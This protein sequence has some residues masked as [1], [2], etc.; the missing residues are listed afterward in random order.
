MYRPAAQTFVSYL[1]IEGKHKI[2]FSIYRLA[3]NLGMSIGPAIGGYIALHSFHSIF[4]VNAF[5]NILGGVILLAGLLDTPWINY[6]PATNNK[7]I[8]TLKW[9]KNDATLRVFI[10]G[11]IP[12]F[13]VF[14]QHESTLG[15]YLQQNL[16]LPL[17]SYGWIFTVNTLMIVCFELLLNI[18]TINWPYRIN[19]IIGS[20][21]ITAGFAGIYFATAMWHI[22]LLTM[23]WTLGEMILYPSASSY[24]ADIAP[25]KYRGGYMSLF[26]TSA[27]LGMLLGPWGGGL[28]MQQLGGQALWIT[29]S[30]FGG[31]S[32]LIFLF[33][34]ESNASK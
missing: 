10:I 30:I 2:T 13:M 19:F 11:I 12:V 34:P 33:L 31:I 8:F 1:S 4:F 26:S 23:V 24:I 32:I 5:S 29:C 7:K 27:N 17:S 16:H 22:I 28:I 20:L 6:F 3:N 9:L 15:V 14:F 25:E 21:L 18:A